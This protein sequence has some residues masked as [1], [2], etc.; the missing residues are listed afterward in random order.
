PRSV[1]TG[2]EDLPPAL[3]DRTKESK[4]FIG[5]ND[6]EETV[7]IA[8]NDSSNMEHGGGTHILDKMKGAFGKLKMPGK[9]KSD[10]TG[11]SNCDV[12]RQEAIVPTRSFPDTTLL[13]T[14]IKPTEKEDLEE[15]I[16]NAQKKHIPTFNVKAPENHLGYPNRLFVLAG[17]REPPQR[18]KGRSAPIIK[19]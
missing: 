13:P 19:H 4:Q 17:P 1:S 18:W 2:D 7:S 5:D 9:K 10:A 12:K 11:T 16:K 3:P 14:Q 6:D 15:V 8:S